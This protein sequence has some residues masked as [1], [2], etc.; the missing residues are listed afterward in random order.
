MHGTLARQAAGLEAQSL[1][2]VRGK[3]ASTTETYRAAVN[4]FVSWANEGGTPW[5]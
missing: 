3:S 1:M 5:G 2:A 4:R